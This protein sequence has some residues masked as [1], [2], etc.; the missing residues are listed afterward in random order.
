MGIEDK[1][2]R[3]VDTCY[4]RNNIFLNSFLQMLE[5]NKNSVIKNY[6]AA[7]Y[8]LEMPFDLDFLGYELLQDAHIKKLNANELSLLMKVAIKMHEQRKKD[9]PSLSPVWTGPI[10][11]ES[12]II[13]KTSETVR[14][15]FQTAKHEI[16]IVGYTFSFDHAQVQPL[17]SDLNL[18]AK[19]GCRIDIIFHQNDSNLSRIK[20]SWPK[21]IFLPNLYYWNG[22]PQDKW[23]SLHSKLILIDQAKLLLTSAN[24]T[25]HGFQKNIE[26]GVMVENHPITGLYWRQFRSLLNNQEMRKYL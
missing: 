20:N 9:E 6:Q 26:T 13:H 24:F 23:A 5:A 4:L 15:L 22:D 10:F 19:R 1:I 11:E 7:L 8:S 25:L 17:F 3:F 21:D 14:H 18:A 2:V 12:P 16:L